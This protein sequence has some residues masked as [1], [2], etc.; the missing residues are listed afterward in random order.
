M[1]TPVAI[2]AKQAVGAAV[3][4]YNV[5]TGGTVTTVGDYKIHTF[6]STGTFNVTAT[7]SVDNTFEILVV[8]GGG[9][10]GSRA[11]GG[12]GGGGLIYMTGSTDLSDVRDFHIEIGAGGVGA[13]NGSTGRGT[14]GGDTL[15]TS[16]LGTVF[17]AKGGGGGGG[18]PYASDGD[19]AD[20]GSGGGGQ[21]FSST[22][23]GQ[24]TQT[25]Q[26]G[27]SG[28]YGFGNDGAPASTSGGEGG[29]GGGAGTGPS[30]SPGSASHRNGGDGLEISINGTATYYAGGGGGGDQCGG[31]AGTGGNGGGGDGGQCTGTITGPTQG[32]NGL[33][34]GGGGGAGDSY[35]G[36]DP[37]GQDGGSGVVIIRYKYQDTFTPASISGL[38]AWWDAQQGTTTTGTDLEVWAD[39]SGNG[40]YA[41]A[42]T[43]REPTLT[44][45]IAAIKNN[46]A[47]SF[48]RTG[49][50]A[51]NPYLQI[52]DASGFGVGSDKPWVPANINNT[53]TVIIVGRTTTTTAG[54]WGAWLTQ[55]GGGRTSVSVNFQQYPDG[56]INFATDNYANGG[57]K[58]TSQAYTNNVFY[59]AV[60]GWSDWATRATGAYLR[61]N[62]N[63]KSISNWGSAPSTPTTANPRMSLFIDIGANDAYIAADIAEIIV[64]DSKLSTTD[65]RLLEDYLRSKYRHYN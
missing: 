23:T 27:N 1:F 24:E 2:L 62:G 21:S 44:S 32:T 43:G 26:T 9:G 56:Y 54:T 16:S 6:T 45:N 33:G 35:Q 39:Q 42:D 55:G 7:G 10:G 17:T 13:I 30:G 47:V 51:S 64:Y 58:D 8:G 29:G 46:S 60:W 4:E 63:D 57:Y 38:V 48:T 65:C 25:S 59:T 19:G 41:N 34:G 36:G 40:F 3:D 12:G 31:T 28:A 11:G 5:A 18:F 37:D 15:I 52:E 20:G 53:R 61:V 50:A 49:T 14:N 22:V